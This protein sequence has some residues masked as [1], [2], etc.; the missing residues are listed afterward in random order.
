MRPSVELAALLSSHSPLGTPSTRKKPT[1]VTGLTCAAWAMERRSQ[2]VSI[3]AGAAAGVRNVHPAPDRS[4][5][6]SLGWPA[7][8]HTGL[9]KNW[10]AASSGTLSATGSSAD[11]GAHRYC[12]QV[13]A[14]GGGA[15]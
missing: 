8:R 11:S 10:A 1:A 13:P 6:Q 7:A 5:G 15:V 12:C 14:A 4:P 3:P 9:T 2:W